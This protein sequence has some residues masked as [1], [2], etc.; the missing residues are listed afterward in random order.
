MSWIGANNHHTAMAADDFALLTDGFDAGTDFHR[1]LQEK[2]WMCVFT[3]SR[4]LVSVG[5]PTSGEVVRGKFNL[6]F[7][8]RKDPDV[9]HAHLSG[10]VGQHLVAVFEFD[11]KHCVGKWLDDHA[12]QQNCIFLRLRQ[13]ILLGSGLVRRT[14]NRSTQRA[15]LRIVRAQQWP[16]VPG[17]EDNYSA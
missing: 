14:Q 1:A 12:L 2:V 6:D 11:A 3:I 17:P 5:D 10:Y 15:D 16:R 7:V 9:M 13:R 8:A 4:L